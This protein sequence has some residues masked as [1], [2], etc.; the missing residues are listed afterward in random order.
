MISTCQP[1][2][3]VGLQSICTRHVSEIVDKKSMGWRQCM[4]G[5]SEVLRHVHAPIMPYYARAW[6]SMV[7]KKFDGDMSASGMFVCPEW[8]YMEE[9]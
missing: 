1:V 8:P 2:H 5:L 9:S 6:S 3:D 4:S 7:M